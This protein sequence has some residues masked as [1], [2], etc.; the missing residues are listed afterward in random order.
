MDIEM[1]REYCLGKIGATEEFPFGPDVL[2]FK[3]GGKMFLLTNLENYPTT[4]NAKCDPERAIELRAEYPA[5]VPGWHMSKKHWNTVSLDG[6]LNGEFVREL[7][8]HSYELVVSKLTKK[9][10]RELGLL[11]E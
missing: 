6:S 10:R 11:D 9:A 1:L 4:F 3:V 2:V 8:D 5:I 7:V